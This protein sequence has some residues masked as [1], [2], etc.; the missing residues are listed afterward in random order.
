MFH[1]HVRLADQLGGGRANLVG[2]PGVPK[3]G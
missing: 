3:G 2:V 1:Q